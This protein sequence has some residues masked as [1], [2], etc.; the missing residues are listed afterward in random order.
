M[1]KPQEAFPTEDQQGPSPHPRMDQEMPVVWLLQPLV[2]GC[3]RS[4]HHGKAM[5]PCLLQNLG[6]VTRLPCPSF[7]L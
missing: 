2:Q 4:R 1:A 3:P 7:P 6:Q 5:S